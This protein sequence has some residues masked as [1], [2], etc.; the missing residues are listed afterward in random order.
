MKRIYRGPR[1]RADVAN[2]V[3]HYERESATLAL[4]FLA[5]YGSAFRL[6]RE[7]PG[8]GS[9]RYA[10]MMGIRGLRCLATPNFPYQLFYREAPDHLVLSRMVHM[11]RDIPSLL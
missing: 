11:S 4:K 3:E 5:A 1:L 8:A 6:L 9:P 2:A 10:Q 7:Y